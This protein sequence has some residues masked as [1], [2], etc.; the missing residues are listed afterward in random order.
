VHLPGYCPAAHAAP[1]LIR[2]LVNPSPLQRCGRY[3][4]LSRY[5]LTSGGALAG[6]EQVVINGSVGYKY[7]AY[8]DTHAINEVLLGPGNALYVVFGDGTK[9]SSANYTQLIEKDNG[10]PGVA[11]W[12]AQQTTPTLNGKILRL[13]CDGSWHCTT[14]VYAYGLRNPWR[15][16]L[17]DGSLWTGD[18]GERTWEEINRINQGGNYGTQSPGTGFHT[19]WPVMLA[20]VSP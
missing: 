5:P 16:G 10:N 1:H 7:C 18:V 2:A 14:S 19:S 3:G 6:P 20:M 9:P 12:M 4:V 11:W 8:A 13:S 15:T 17:I